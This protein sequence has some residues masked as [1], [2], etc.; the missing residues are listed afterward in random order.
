MQYENEYIQVVLVYRKPG[1]IGNFID[2]LIEDLRS[3]SADYRTLII[4][5]FNLDQRLQCN[6]NAIE[7][8][9]TEFKMVQRS[10]FSTHIHGGILDLIL[11]NG[12]CCDNVS[13]IPTPFSDHFILIFE[14]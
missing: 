7:P 4:G 8:L 6:V 10:N 14:I 11:D 1:P 3:L 2:E 5:D 9:L 13:W 12:N